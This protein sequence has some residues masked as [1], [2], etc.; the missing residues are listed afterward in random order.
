MQTAPI[1]A[2]AA[3]NAPSDAPSDAP[4][5]SGAAGDT[6]VN[7]GADAAIN[8]P[9]ALQPGQ[10]WSVA[11]E[12][13]PEQ[14]VVSIGDGSKEAIAERSET[15]G[16]VVETL[17]S[18]SLTLG[19]VEISVFDVLLVVATIGLGR[20]AIWTSMP[21]PTCGCSFQSLL[22]TDCLSRTRK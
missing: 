11:Q 22:K 19:D 1:I 18:W 21:A 8:P 5:P 20:T 9:G 14:E 15:L 12:H 10:V 17:D 2:V 6:A 7:S 3:T 16:A 4:A 13:V